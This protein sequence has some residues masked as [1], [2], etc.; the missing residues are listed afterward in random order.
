MT[1][2]SDTGTTQVVTA[3]HAP[4][5]ENHKAGA[6]RPWTKFSHVAP[7]LLR[8]SGIGIMSGLI[9]GV[10]VLGL[11]GRIAM[12]VVALA[13]GEEPRFTVLGT[14]A[15]L[16]AFGVLSAPLGLAFVAWFRFLPR[17]GVWSGAG[18]GIVLFI[19]VAGLI[20]VRRGGVGD[21]A[22]HLVSGSALLGGLLVLHG[23]GLSIATEWVERWFLVAEEMSHTVARVTS[24]AAVKLIQSLVDDIPIGDLDVIQQ[25]ADEAVDPLDL[26]FTGN[27]LFSGLF[28]LTTKLLSDR[29][30]DEG[31][32][33]A[34][35]ERVGGI[36][37]HSY[38]KRHERSTE[39]WNRTGQFRM[40]ESGS[41]LSGRF[42]TRPAWPTSLM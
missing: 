42:F 26:G 32:T 21:L 36:L 16:A 29:L 39:F 24:R 13:N 11:S 40:R 9:A 18:F 15:V 8:S 22:N 41:G 33:V 34:R 14:L 35:R 5:H 17:A 2:Q 1:A 3:D 10:L 27:S 4:A 25:V 28:L 38:Q 12:R 7:R 37:S 20:I 23:V 31:F 6:T 19:L 30:L